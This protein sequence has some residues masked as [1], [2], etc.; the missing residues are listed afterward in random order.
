MSSEVSSRKANAPARADFEAAFTV[1]A[2]RGV[3]AVSI[4]T[5]EITTATGKISLTYQLER[6]RGAAPIYDEVYALDIARADR[7]DG[8]ARTHRVVPAVPRQARA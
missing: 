2:V 1:R 6:W 4:G 7:V 5:V 8:L 3:P